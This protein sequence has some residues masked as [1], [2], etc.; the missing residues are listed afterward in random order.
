M[1]QIGSQ[2]TVELDAFVGEYVSQEF[3]LSQN[4][5]YTWPFRT[6]FAENNLPA[7]QHLLKLTTQAGATVQSVVVTSGDG[8]PE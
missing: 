1:I 8:I 2:Y 4:A 7:G 5:T 3:G 6:I